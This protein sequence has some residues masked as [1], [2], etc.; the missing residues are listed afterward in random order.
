MNSVENKYQS[1]DTFTNLH[2]QS[3]NEVEGGYIFTCML[4]SV[5]P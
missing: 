4:L 1:F 3:A 5:C 2:Q